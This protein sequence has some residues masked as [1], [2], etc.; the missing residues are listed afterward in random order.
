MRSVFCST[1]I[2]LFVCA[3]SS[4]AYAAIEH[5]GVPSAAVS[6]RA[7]VPGSDSG[8]SMTD[9]QQAAVA[10]SALN[11]LRSPGTVDAFAEAKSRATSFDSVGIYA[12][13]R[14]RSYTV[15]PDGG[16][17]FARASAGAYYNS[18]YVVESDSL[19]LGSPVQLS[20]RVHYDG[21]VAFDDNGIASGQSIVRGW[22]DTEVYAFDWD[23]NAVFEYYGGAGF[24]T[25]RGLFAY[26]DWKDRFSMSTEDPLHGRAAI[27][28]CEDLIV[29]TK[30]G[31]Q[32]RLYM[33][34]EAQFET[35][36]GA[37]VAFTV[38]FLHTGSAALSTLD[39]AV[40]VTAVVPEPV[41]LSLLGLGATTLLRR[42][43]RSTDDSL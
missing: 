9:G 24:D 37:D 34:L 12:A 16:Y 25:D 29:N 10:R 23:D 14:N 30:V 38:D 1:L 36:S 43:R 31:A 39:P 6:A 19:P 28:Y 42:R 32:L 22:I 4:S 40:R 20:I 7:I 15:I 41:S 13:V 3:S 33:G 35:G 17:S 11:D 5:W 21:T 26:G 27:D 2:G 8:I 18:D